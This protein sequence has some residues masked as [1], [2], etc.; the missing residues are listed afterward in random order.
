VTVD[1]RNLTWAGNGAGSA[2]YSFD[3][4]TSDIHS[5][6]YVGFEVWSGMSLEIDNYIGGQT[7]ILNVPID[8]FPFAYD[9]T[10]YNDVLTMSWFN[11]TTWSWVV[12]YQYSYD[13]GTSFVPLANLQVNDFEGGVTS[14]SNMTVY[15]GLAVPIGG[16]GGGGGSSS[17]TTPEPTLTPSSSS[18][19]HNNS[20]I[21][22]VPVW[23]W[24]ATGATGMG[25]VFV[26]AIA[27]KV[28]PRKSRKKR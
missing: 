21:A 13:S 6:I 9:I 22:Q 14:S 17:V 24:V 10:L 7:S 12:G 11:A 1:A 18:A 4:C 28:I 3:L 19:P 25:A 15:Y 2:V 27:V 26:I 23:V 5:P 20:S 8:T 16:G